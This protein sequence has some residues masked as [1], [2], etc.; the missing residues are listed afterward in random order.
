MT[1]ANDSAFP[2]IPP[3]DATGNHI[4]GYPYPAEGLTKLEYFAAMAMQ[5][6]VTA[7]MDEPSHNP[8]DLPRKGAQWSVQ[9]AK[10]LIAEL[11]KA[12]GGEH[13]N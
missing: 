6:Y 13:A 5:G 7:V 10:A 8:L 11:A 2:V 1:K 9:F 4:P 12:Q 3:L